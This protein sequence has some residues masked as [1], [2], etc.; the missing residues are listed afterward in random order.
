M[1]SRWE[2]LAA[3]APERDRVILCSVLEILL[4]P[5]LAKRALWPIQAVEAKNSEMEPVLT[6]VLSALVAGA[7]A[8][9]KEVAGQA[10]SDSYDGLKSLLIRKLGK[11]GAVQSLEDEPES[12][13]ASE[14]LA[15]ALVKNGLA[16]DVELASRAET[17]IQA[18]AEA[19]TS[20]FSGA[21]DIEIATVRGRLNATVENLSAEGRIKLG[22]VVAEQGDA[23]V[24]DFT[25]GTTPKNR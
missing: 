20:G 17:V 18:L 12:G 5:A 1:T 24:R 25:A 11:T 3:A 8:K 6:T 19:N 4:V 14:A 2:C 21:A 13:P 16:E 15:E 23:A 10:V 22:P 9:A 7:A